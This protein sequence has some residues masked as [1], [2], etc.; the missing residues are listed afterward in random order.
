MAHPPVIADQHLVK[1]MNR[2]VL[3]RM[4][5]GEPGMS[6]ADLAECSGLTRSTVSVLIKELIDEGWLVESAA[7]VTGTPG[8]R[9]TPLSVDG[10]R[11][12][13]VGAELGP[14]ALCVVTTSIRGDVMESSQAPLRSKDP[15]AACHQL[16]EMITA[17]ASKVI[18]GGARLLGIGV[19]LH[20][21]VDKRSGLLL[22]A[23]NIGWRNVEVG[24]YLDAE[25]SSAGLAHVPVYF[26]NEATLAAV[27][28]FEFG[29]RN[30]DDPL[31][32]ISCGI[33]VG[34]GIILNEALFTGAT[35]SAGEIGHITLVIDGE[36]CTCGRR[37]CAEAYIGLHAIAAAACGDRD[38][39]L[40]RAE[41]HER[42]AWRHPATRAA[43]E[44]AGR[45]LGVLMQDM[46]AT[47]NP[48]AIVLGGE[49]VALGGETFLDAASSVLE[50]VA[51]RVGMPAPAVRLTRH[52][53]RAAAVGAAAYVLHAILYPHQPA[54]HTRYSAAIA[55]GGS[56]RETRQV[57]V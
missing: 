6:R 49:T 44:G 39:A 10:A 40:D 38:A 25:L 5:H 42:M 23:P 32:Y 11:I 28:E 41:L 2:M 35:G 12:M 48:S 53:E 22:F 50:D 55:N 45:S 47:L 43:F 24:R 19:A 17:H 18:Q 33:G 30:L 9:P 8:R 15:D 14:D 13:L 20:G 29:P 56:G 4:L 46:W 57:P 27:G 54:V 37:G 26:H 34:A 36:P 7:H 1:N 3:L 16:V 51:T 52:A 31:I 21:A